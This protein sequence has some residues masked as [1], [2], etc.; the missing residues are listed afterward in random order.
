MEKGKKLTEQEIK[1]IKQ[2]R[3]KLVKGN[4]VVRK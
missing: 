2:E 4:N 3:E 1:A